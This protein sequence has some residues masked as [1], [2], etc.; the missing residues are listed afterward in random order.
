VA[1]VRTDG[2]TAAQYRLPTLPPDPTA[3][4]PGPS[5]P[6]LAAP[7]EPGRVVALLAADGHVL[8][9]TSTPAAAG[10]TDLVTART[11]TFGGYTNV[12]ATTTGGDGMVYVVTAANDSAFSQ[13]I[14]RIDPRSMRI[15][16]AFDTGTLDRGRPATA[17]PTRYGAVVYSPGVPDSLDALSG[18]EL[19]L[20]DGAGLRENATVSSDDGLLM[21]PGKGDSVLLYGGPAGDV[22]TRV[23]IDD[24]AVRRA[25]PPPTPPSGTV[26]VLAAD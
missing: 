3:L 21:G 14:L 9:V 17:L 12:R 16:S 10:L 4:L 20:I 11:V 25:D 18:T 1:A 19:W 13:R 7:I 22:V 6:D 15:V 2:R 5:Q 26:V 8:A 24:G 23:G